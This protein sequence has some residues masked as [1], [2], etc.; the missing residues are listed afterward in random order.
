MIKLE[1]IFILMG[2]VTGGA[3]VVNAFDATNPR[4]L[5]NTVFWGLYSVTFLA[6]SHLSDFASGLIVLGMVGAAAI[7]GLG[8]GAKR[9]EQSAKRLPAGNIVFLPALLVPALTVLGTYT[10]KGVTVFGRPLVDPTQV[11]QVSL[12][13]ATVV[14]LCVGLA[15][16]RP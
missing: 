15:I 11:T 8:E 13:L 10:L 12:G 14:A 16:F 7:R 2:L 4:R 5:N 3:A 1:F 6:G 9:P